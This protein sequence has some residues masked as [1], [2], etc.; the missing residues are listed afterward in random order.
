MASDIGR[1]GSDHKA[2]PRAFQARAICTT[3]AQPWPVPR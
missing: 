3:E 2:R 1:P